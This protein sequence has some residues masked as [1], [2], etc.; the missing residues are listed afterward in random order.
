M[1]ALLELFGYV[2]GQN[3]DHTW[4]VG[5]V[6]LPCC[7]RCAGLYAGA[8][9]AGLAL[10]VLRPRLTD[11]LQQAHGLFLV[12]MLPFGFHLV[13]QEAILRTITGVLFGFGVVCFLWLLPGPARAADGAPAA[14]TWRQRVYWGA[15]FGSVMAV[16]ALA[17]WGGP[18]A[19]IGLT[20][21]A[22][23]GLATLALLVLLNLG[24]ALRALAAWLKRGKSVAIQ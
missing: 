5:G 18:A 13:P 4:C 17:L 15:V 16:P 10:L 24:C 12:I 14:T 22:A 23:G 8:A 11:R 1:D 2:C 20:V 3:P 21:L 7:Q 6:W 9:L 19:A